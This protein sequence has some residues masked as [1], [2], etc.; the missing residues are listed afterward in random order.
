MTGGRQLTPL[1][2]YER[3]ARSSANGEWRNSV[4]SIKVGDMVPLSKLARLLATLTLGLT[5]LLVSPGVHAQYPPPGGYATPPR[6]GPQ[7]AP[8]PPGYRQPGYGAPTYQQPPSRRVSTGLELGYLYGTSITWGV[9]T[10]IWIDAEADIGDP[11]LR[12]IP[13][14]LLGGVAPVG[15]YLIDRFAYRQGMPEGMPSA[16]ATG[17]I[18]GA[19]E[20]LAIAGTQWSRASAEDEWGFRGLARAETISSTL[21]G[22]GGFALYY[23]L[24]PKPQTNIFIASSAFWGATIGSFFGGGASPAKADWGRTNDDVSLGGLIGFNLGV[25]G[26]IG[27][28]LLWT[29]SWHQLGWMW[30]GLG[31][32]TAASL[33][34]YIFYAASSG[35]YDP[36]RGLIF[37]G[38]AGTIGLT[39][40]GLFSARRGPVAAPSDRER[41]RRAERPVQLWSVSPMVVNHGLGVQFTGGLW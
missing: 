16:I 19:G 18:I 21:G 3:P 39:L 27:T 37:Q 24:R 31:I 13:P 4:T 5:L 7:P 26:S 28:S 14:L 38:V 25:A 8:L 11:G 6:Y 34:V 35:D 15:V 10:G 17:M 23:F 9:G 20:G 22:A 1:T 40:G 29:P 33:P 36:R 12:L 32:G 41:Q 2:G 30:G